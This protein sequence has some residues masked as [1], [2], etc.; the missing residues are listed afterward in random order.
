METELEQLRLEGRTA[1]V[2]AGRP[3]VR[4]SAAAAPALRGVERLVIPAEVETFYGLN[5]FEDLR[6][7]EYAGAADVF[8]F[9]E[10]LDWLAEKAEADEVEF[11]YRLATNIMAD[12]PI[13]PALIAVTAPNMVPLHAMA[14]HARLLTVLDDMALHRNTRQDTARENIFLCVSFVQLKRLEYAMY[15]GRARFNAAYAP[16]VEVWY[17]AERRFD[18]REAFLYAL[19][20]L[21]GHSYQTFYTAGGANS[22]GNLRTKEDY[23][24]YLQKTLPLEDTD[25]LRRQLLHLMDLELLTGENW[26]AA[27]E[28]LLQAR[29]TEA[30]AFLLDQGRRRWPAAPGP[31]FLDEEFQL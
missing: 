12:R 18:G 6:V 1:L 25:A 7:V 11:L 4:L 30:T 31:D 3:A 2:R 27:L 22:Y 19:A 14:S 24:R 5:R 28:I 8:G 10:A 26:R 29:L 9:R 21:R 17:P 23:V 16:E 20:L 15:L 13:S